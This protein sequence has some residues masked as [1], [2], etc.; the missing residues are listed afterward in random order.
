MRP[1][2]VSGIVI[3][4]SPISY[5]PTSSL[6]LIIVPEAFAKLTRPS[7]LLFP[8]QRRKGKWNQDTSRNCFWDRYRRRADQLLA[9]FFF[10]LGNSPR[11]LCESWLDP[12]SFSSHFRDEKGNRN[13]MRPA[14][15]SGIVYWRRADQL[16]GTLRSNDAMVTRMLLKKWICF[17]SVF[18]AIIPTHLLCQMKVNPP[19]VEFLRTNPSSEKEIKF[20]CCLFTS[21]IKSK[22]WAFS[23][24]SRAKT[25]K[26][27]CFAYKT[28]CFVFFDVLVVIRV[29]GSKVTNEC[30]GSQQGR[31]GTK[32]M[33]SHSKS[34]RKTENDLGMKD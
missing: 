31:L 8:L 25:G 19:G 4:D 11:S 9:N 1:A 16:L 5:W 18:I 29:V 26:S 10:V 14:I 24:R 6:S 15:V 21:S 30:Y 22:I 32:W 17:L 23:R 33:T 28:Y 7:F 34:S 13:K 12:V 2:I 20:R 27:C 3:T